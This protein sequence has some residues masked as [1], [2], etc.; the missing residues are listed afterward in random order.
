ME[1]AE[2]GMRN[3]ECFHREFEVSLRDF[4][5]TYSA[6]RIPKSALLWEQRTTDNGQ[7]AKL[8]ILAPVNL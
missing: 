2:S 7:H 8:V 3:V 1:N 5:S 4:T 6:F